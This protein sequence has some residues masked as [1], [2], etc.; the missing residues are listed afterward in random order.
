MFSESFEQYLS[1]FID[2]NYAASALWMFA[3]GKPCPY[4][5]K[6]HTLVAHVLTCG[7]HAMV[8]A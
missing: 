7:P 5:H 8:G 6:P 4:D 1:R 3:K 2:E